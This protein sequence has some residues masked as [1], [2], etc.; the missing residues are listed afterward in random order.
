MLRAHLS[1]FQYCVNRISDPI[2][3]IL[4]IDVSKHFCAA[5]K[6]GGG[7][8]YIFTNSFSVRMPCTL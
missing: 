7:T 2:T 3:V 1:S 8:R 4:Q 5:Q 6:E